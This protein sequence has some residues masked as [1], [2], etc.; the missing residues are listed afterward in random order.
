MFKRTD[1]YL[2]S[3]PANLSLTSSQPVV[4]SNSGEDRHGKNRMSPPPSVPG[5]R[6]DIVRLM[7]EGEERVVK[8]FEFLPVAR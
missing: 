7:E 6:D 3:H 5:P 1:E 2:S 4:R 8:N